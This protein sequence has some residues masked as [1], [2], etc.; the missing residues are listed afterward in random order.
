MSR[1]RLDFSLYGGKAD[2]FLKVYNKLSR[3]SKHTISKPGAVI[4]LIKAFETLTQEQQKTVVDAVCDN[5]KETSK[6]DGLFDWSGE[7]EILIKK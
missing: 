1:V 4:M 3:I 5:L 2:A 7:T 6:I